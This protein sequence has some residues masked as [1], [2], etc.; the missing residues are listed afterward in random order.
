MRN[1]VIPL[2]TLILSFM[3]GTAS[4]SMIIS[5]Q[6]KFPV[7]INVTVCK[8]DPQVCWGDEYLLGALNQNNDKVNIALSVNGIL[9]IEKAL[10]IDYAGKIIAQLVN[11]CRTSV[12]T[13][14]IILNDNGS[15]IISCQYE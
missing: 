2:L 15:S 6:S 10:E 4:A 7:T 3:A 14:H 9:T 11:S 13:K 12:S 1:L 5:N 8:G